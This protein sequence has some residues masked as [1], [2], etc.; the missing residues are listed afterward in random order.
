MNVE[1]DRHGLLACAVAFASYA[2]DGRLRRGTG[3][4]EIVHSMETVSIAATLTNDPEVLAAAVLHDVTEDCGVSENELRVRFGRRVAQLV[5]SV[6]EERVEECGGSWQK[7]KLYAVSRLAAA[8]R[9]QMI[10]T[11]ADKLSNLRAIERELTA[12]GPERWAERPQPGLSM[13]RWYYGSV[14][15]LLSPLADSAA[16]REYM[17]RLR[18]IFPSGRTEGS[19]SRG[20][21]GSA[22]PL[23]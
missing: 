16:H 19:D 10:L 7:R 18:R 4:P 1:F 8:T 11:L 23:P 2:H 22:E 13:Y 20:A 9:E 3:V 12:E 6:S 15:E 17:E 21:V 14:G 5:G